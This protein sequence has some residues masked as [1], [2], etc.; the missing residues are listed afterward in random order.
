MIRKS[1]LSTHFFCTFSYFYSEF[2][3]II[4]LREVVIS[5]EEN[6]TFLHKLTK[7]KETFF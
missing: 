7:R 4:L 1:G 5:G 2:L 6:R 3:A